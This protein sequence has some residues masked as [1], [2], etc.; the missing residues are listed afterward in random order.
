MLRIAVDA[1]PLAHPHTGIGRYTEEL[2]RRLTK[3]G[4]QWLLYSDRAITPRFELDDHVQIRQGRTTPGTPL[5]LIYSQMVFPRWARGDCV[6]VFWSPRHHL[7][8]RLSDAVPGVVTVHD[9]V[10]RRFPETMRVRNRWLEGRLMAPSLRK[11]AGIIAVSDFTR[12]ELLAEYPECAA[13]CVTIHEAAALPLVEYEQRHTLPDM[14]FFL[15]VGTPEPRKN[16]EFTL[17]AFR[18]CLDA[19]LKH[20][21][22]LVGADGWGGVSADRLVSQY[23]LGDAVI[24]RG[25]VSDAELQQLYA[26]ATALLFPSLYEGFGLP[27]L[28]SM[29][30][31]TPVIAS[32][33]GALPEVVGDAG[34]YVDPES[35]E[36]MTKAIE[37]L[38]SDSE[39]R[40]RLSELASRR[41]DE[42]SW[43]DS[44]NRTLELLEAVVSEGA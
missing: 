34:L 33:R 2:L 4:H 31:G 21:L 9:L 10:W 30:L 24:V 11:A 18:A 20:R 27:A 35:F 28:E 43:N 25:R 19:G 8:L 14:P 37:R 6:D 32:N 42:F 1:R 3:T 23:G 29:R 40:G 36:S 41:A 22:V 16:L 5:S 12:G 26:S 44:A 39:E 15:F 38:A 7:P 13:R 17:C